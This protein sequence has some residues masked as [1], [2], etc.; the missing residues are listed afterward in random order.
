MTQDKLNYLLVLAEEQNVTRAARRLYITQ[1]TLTGFLNRLEQDLGFRIFDRQ[2]SPVTLTASGKHYIDGMQK[3]LREEHELKEK[4][5]CE[6]QSRIQFRIGIGQV[7][8]QMLS[9][10]LA[11]KL[12]EQH[13]GLNLQFC[14]SKESIL[15]DMLR[16][17]EIDLFVGHA[18]I[19]STVYLSGELSTE[20]LSLY[21]PDSFLNLS[22]E[23][24][25][26]NSPEN[27]YELQ[28]ELSLRRLA[29]RDSI[30][31]TWTW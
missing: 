19:G 3:L 28:P 2:S 5:R 25:S 27:L 7:H 11:E 29:H 23:E 17:G 15:L 16:R 18:Q 1:P 6:A 22:A 4:L 10:I 24:R 12:I 21:M 30:S 13:P 31:I 26:Q 8:S 9:P 14:E 20:R